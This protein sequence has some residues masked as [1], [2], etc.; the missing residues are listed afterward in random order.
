MEINEE[1]F[2]QRLM[3]IEYIRRELENYIA[4]LNSLQATQDTVNKSLLGLSSLK[5]F[6]GEVLMPYSQDIFLRANVSDS[7][8][9]LVNLGSNI[10]KKV[11]MD[12]LRTR[13]EKDSEEISKNISQIADII[14]KLQ[15]QGGTLEREANEFYEEYRKSLK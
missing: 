13:L 9:A 8:S 1:D 7:S 12:E 5:S 6:S 11:G 14:R 10:L 15:E 3:E 2:S 4:A